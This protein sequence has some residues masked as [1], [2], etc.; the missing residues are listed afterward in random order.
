MFKNW[1]EAFSQKENEQQDEQQNGQR[2]VSYIWVLA[3]G[4]LIYLGGKLLWGFY[5]GGE[6]RAVVALLAGIV[7]MVVGGL[8]IRREWFAYRSSTQNPAQGEEPEPE[9]LPE[10]LELEELEEELSE[11]TQEE[12]DL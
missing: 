1:K 11:E 7:F 6:G 5:Q 12:A 9:E 2:N 3:G 8:V 4:Y 10:E